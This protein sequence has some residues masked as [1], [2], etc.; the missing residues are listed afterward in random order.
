VLVVCGFVSDFTGKQSHVFYPSLG[1]QGPD[2]YARVAEA[3]K[4]L[5]IWIVH[6]DADQNVSVE[7]SAR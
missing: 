2:R 6:G 3:V 7:E 4:K 5:P 1:G